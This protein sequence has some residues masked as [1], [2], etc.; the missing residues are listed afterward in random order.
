MR[1]SLAAALGI[2]LIF[3]LA[4]C[5]NSFAQ[6]PSSPPSIKVAAVDFVPAW[7][8]LDGN[9]RR[10]AQAAEEVAR[11]GVAYAVFPETALSGYLFSG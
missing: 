5:S 4:Y 7:G 11:Q 8:D 6:G 2:G 3:G 10:L 1:R 9:V